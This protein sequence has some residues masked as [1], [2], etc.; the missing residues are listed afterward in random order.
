MI[1]LARCLRRYCVRRSTNVAGGR[2]AIDGMPC[3]CPLTRWQVTH[4]AERYSPKARSPAAR[5]VPNPAHQAS[6]TSAASATRIAVDI[7]LL[8]FRSLA[9]VR[10]HVEGARPPD[11]PC[12]A[13]RAI[14]HA[15]IFV[16]K[17]LLGG[18][19]VVVVKIRRIAELDRGEIPVVQLEILIRDDV[20]EIEHIGR[21]GI[22]LVVGQR[23]RVAVRHGAADVIHEGRGVGL[24]AWPELANL[25]IPQ[26]CV[27]WI[28]ARIDIASV[29]KIFP[30]SN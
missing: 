3:E 4:S 20:V 13:R 6:A 7:A 17:M 25:L 16:P 8:Y 23:L 28:I 10:R 21:D 29:A 12:R 15:R 1:G 24:V 5:A 27:R 11:D 14:A 22:E 18:L 19:A 2:P 9:G 30:R 26:L